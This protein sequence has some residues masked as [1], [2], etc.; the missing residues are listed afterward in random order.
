MTTE[1]NKP[2]AL[3]AQVYENEHCVNSFDLDVATYCKFGYV[4]CTPQVFLMGRPVVKGAD[5]HLLMDCSYRFERPD[6]WWIFLAA[7]DMTEFFRHEPF[8]LPY[9][10]WERKNKPRWWK[11]KDLI[12]WLK[13]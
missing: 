7:G 12:R 2:L 3:A 8:Q 4:I 1:V 6:C 9:F 13:Q 10:G 5:Y 11:R